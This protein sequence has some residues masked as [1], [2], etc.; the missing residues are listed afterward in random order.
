MTDRVATAVRVVAAYDIPAEA[1]EAIRVAIESCAGRRPRERCL[2]RG[3]PSAWEVIAEADPHRL[4]PAVR[5]VAD[6]HGV[7]ACV[8]EAG[9]RARRRLVVLDVDSTLIEQ[10]VIELIAEHAGTAAEVAAV[11]EA[12]M[13]GEVDFAESLRARVATLAGLDVAVLAEVRRAVRLTP[14]ARPLVAVLHAYGHTVG[15]VSGGFAEILEPLAAELGIDHTRANRLEVAT[16]RLTGRVDGAIVDRAGKAASLR[17]WAQRDGVDPDQVVAVGDGANDLDM[18]AAAGLGIAFCAKPA[19]RAAADA[20][21]SVRRLDLVLHLLG[22]TQEQ[23]EAA[24]AGPQRPPEF[25]TWDSSGP[26]L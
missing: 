5:A 18:L 20:T 6:A 10:E 23:V 22:F 21:I 17:Q 19:V 1:R 2:R 25:T 8:V 16:G 3:S 26:G 4:R 7:D 24:V 15:V 9:G 11:T 13:R 14:G 12:A